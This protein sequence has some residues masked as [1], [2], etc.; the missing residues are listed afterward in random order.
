MTL[1]DANTLVVNKFPKI[2]VFLS[3]WKLDSFLILKIGKTRTE[4]K[5][6]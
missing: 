6:F 2:L 5:D 1:G 4:N 3:S